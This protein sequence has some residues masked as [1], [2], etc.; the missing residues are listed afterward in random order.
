MLNA[1]LSYFAVIITE[2]DCTVKQ[3][4]ISSNKCLLGKNDKSSVEPFSAQSSV[5]ITVMS[6]VVL[7]NGDKRDNK[8]IVI[9]HLI[10]S[11][12]SLALHYQPLS[13]KMY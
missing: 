10:S 5:Y 8:A 13:Q 9:L 11:A 3:N 1:N 2:I 4:Y 6:S 7:L 12:Y